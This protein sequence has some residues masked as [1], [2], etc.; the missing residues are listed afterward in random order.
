MKSKLNSSTPTD[1]RSFEYP[2]A[3]IDSDVNYPAVIAE[4]T[5]LNNERWIDIE[6]D[7]AINLERILVK[8]TKNIGTYRIE[9]KFVK[10]IVL[11]H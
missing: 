8:V 4:Q 6:K 10:K 1:K 11:L 2:A 5:T 7:N 9:V 3:K